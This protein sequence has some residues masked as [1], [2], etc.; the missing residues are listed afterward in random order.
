[1]IDLCKPV[2]SFAIQPWLDYFIVLLGWAFPASQYIEP[3]N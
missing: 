1:M 3:N 2:A